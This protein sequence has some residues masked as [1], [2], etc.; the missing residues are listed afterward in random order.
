M[1]PA[2]PISLTGALPATSS[3]WATY[4]R[5]TCSGAGYMGSGVGINTIQFTSNTPN[6]ECMMLLLEMLLKQENIIILCHSRLYN[7]QYLLHILLHWDFNALIPIWHDAAEFTPAT[8]I[9]AGLKQTDLPVGFCSAGGDVDEKRESAGKGQRLHVC[10]PE[11]LCF[12]TG[13]V[14]GGETFLAAVVCNYFTRGPFLIKQKKEKKK[15]CKYI[16]KKQ[17]QKQAAP[18][19]C[20]YFQSTTLFFPWEK[21]Y[22]FLGLLCAAAT[23][24]CR[25][26]CSS[27]CSGTAEVGCH[28][29][30]AACFGIGCD[31][32]R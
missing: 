7:S 17:K 10:D 5:H 3:C 14:C 13:W 32:W 29:N 24:S 11:K 6:N 31:S 8:G 23:V 18:R 1:P 16:L 15:I 19:D 21:K 4:R 26:F 20:R 27:S 12:P 2:L 25:C 30:E 28:W 9:Q 22:L